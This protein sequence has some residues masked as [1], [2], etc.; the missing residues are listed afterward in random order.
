MSCIRT[1]TGRLVDLLDVQVFDLSIEDTAHALSQA[2]RWSAM[3][4]WHY[5]IAQH[6][7]LMFDLLAEHG[8]RCPR[9]LRTTLLHDGPEALIGDMPTPLKHS[10]W[11]QPYR[12]LEARIWTA[13]VKR[14]DLL[15]GIPDRAPR[16]A[17]NCQ[18]DAQL[19]K[20]ADNVLLATEARDLMTGVILPPYLPDALPRPTGLRGWACDYSTIRRWA[21]ARAKAEFLSRWLE[22][23]VAPADPA[24]RPSFVPHPHAAGGLA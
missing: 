11:A 2:C 9:A 16:S 4:R 17:L 14:F 5:S 3:T 22:V 8:V 7:V 18:D 10:P 20:W 19:I 21:P 13:Y 15:P 24:P 23:Y 1:Y 12:A 6:S